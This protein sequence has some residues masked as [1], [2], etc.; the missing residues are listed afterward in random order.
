MYID[1]PEQLSTDLFSQR[2]IYDEILEIEDDLDRQTAINKLRLRAK[3]LQVTKMFDD[4]L[5]SAQRAFSKIQKRELNDSLETF[6]LM[7]TSFTMLDKVLSKDQLKC[8]DWVAD[9][10]G[11]RLHSDKG[12]M[13][14]CPHPIIISKTLRNIE[15]GKYK[16]E[17]VYQ[18][19][20]KTRQI[21]SFCVDRKTIASASKILDIAD[22]GVIVTSL[23]A[24]LLVKYLADLQTLNSELV[25]EIPSTSRLGWVNGIDSDGNPIKQFLPYQ[26]KIEFDNYEMM[27]LFNS[28]QPHGDSDKWYEL[29][30]KIRAKRQP[31]VLINL[32]ASFASVLVE[33]C[34]GLPFIV[35]L[36][37]GT[38]IG[39]TVILKL[40]TS[41]WANPKE[42]QYIAS[43]K[44]TYVGTEQQ[45][46]ILNSLPLMIDDM[47]QLT[48]QEDVKLQEIIYNVCAG[49]GKTRG[50][51][52]GGTRANTHWK[53][54]TITNGE[55]SFVDESMQGGAINRVIDIEASGEALF[56][57]KEGND[58]IKV[59]EKNYG[60]A[61]DDFI[62][63]ITQL[64]MEKLLSIYNEQYERVKEAAKKKGVEK[65]D[66]QV[67][68]MA[69]ILT[70]DEISE[71]YLFSDEVTIDIDQA[72]DYLRSKGEISENKN[73]YEYLMDI[74]AANYF[75]FEDNEDPRESD[76]ESKRPIERWGYWKA[77][78]IVVI[79]G[80]IFEQIMKK[81]GFQG[82]S[83]LSWA[84]KNKLLEVGDDGRLKK[85]IN[86]K[87]FSGR[88][89]V[90]KTTYGNPIETA[91]L[92]D[93]TDDDYK[94]LPFK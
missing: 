24:P 45:L 9:D 71:K 20:G 84:N 81:G 33:P 15:T 53:N 87:I 7:N 44:S 68:P 88:G 56:T 77:E 36:W 41:I 65:E 50:K 64:G 42:G 57:G 66:K 35:S 31:E 85:K 61:G 58:T 76:D 38:G 34:G 75:R 39:K 1:Y 54:C 63:Q 70:A 22:D 30:K 91:V 18:L 29:V 21:R 80:T 49:Q 94:D 27:Y 55:R 25:V 28:I 8:G 2:D 10:D 43:S 48:M 5:K 51:K 23:T 32:A 16:A 73:A 52:E 3:E 72:I 59:I 19:P 40:C 89:V 17:I 60:H 37:G 6:G 62:Y 69:L 82:K 12:L 83:F 79:N 78:D 93:S 90:I 74:I 92:E 67:A 26:S 13:W 86:N 14:A 11:V 47:A 4:M 46:N